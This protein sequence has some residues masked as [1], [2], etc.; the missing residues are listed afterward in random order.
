MSR[1]VKSGQLNRN[2]QELGRLGT[3]DDRDAREVATAFEELFR[4]VGEDGSRVSAISGSKQKKLSLL[5]FDG[6]G[7][8]GLFSLLV[9]ERLIA[10]VQRLEPAGSPTRLPCEYFDLIGGTSTGGLLAIMLSR[11]RMDVSSCIQAYQDMSRSIFGRRDDW[12]PLW[13]PL[14]K[15]VQAMVGEPWFSGSRLEDAINEIVERRLSVSE[16]DSLRTAGLPVEDV[17]LLSTEGFNTRCF[18]C[19]VCEGQHEAERIRSYLPLSREG[20]DTSAYTIWQAGRATAAAPMYFPAIDIDSRHYFDGGLSCNNPVL[21]VIDETRSEFPGAEIDALI[22]IGTGK[23]LVSEAFGSAPQVIMGIIDRLT[24]TEAQHEK[25]MKNAEFETI[26]ASYFRFQEDDGLK[27]IG[28]AGWDKLDEI[29]R[30]A[31]AYL[32]DAD[33]QRQLERAARSILRC[34]RQ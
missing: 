27:F 3:V 6:G 8:R 12:I 11:L 2:H 9:L 20:R 16:R 7:V 22:S 34:L 32:D 17:R 14:K 1:P 21:E 15:G 24:T 5:S 30:L 33:V 29:E 23:G 4:I 26:R 10:E 19:A 31:K 18:V 25:L 13:N 28:L